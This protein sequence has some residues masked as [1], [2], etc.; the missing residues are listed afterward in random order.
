MVR[1]RVK[2]RLRHLTRSRLERLPAGALVVVR[3]NPAAATASSLES[4][5]DSALS[6]V[7]R[8]AS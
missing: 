3:A 5:L 1:N 8:S 2:R 4:D 7:L 6:S